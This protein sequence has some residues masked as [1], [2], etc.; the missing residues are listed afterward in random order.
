MRAAVIVDGR[1][2]IQERPDPVPGDGE[3]LIRV[4]AAGINGADLMQRAGNYPPPPGAPPDIPGLECAGETE[5]GE[6]VMALLAGGGQ[7][8]LAVVHESH[9]LPVP[10]VVGWPEAGG[11]VEAF[12][13][14]HDALFS[15]AELSA[16]ERLLVNGAAGGVGVAAVQLGLAAGAHVT[17]SARHH[18]DELR[19]LGADTDV[20]SEY[21]VI[22]ELVG[23]ENLASNLTRLASKGRVAVIGTGAGARIELDF[24]LLMR[25]RGRIHGSMLRAR[26]IAEKAQVMTALAAFT[27]E[28]TFRVPV[29]ETFP[30][31]RTQDAY[32]RF[33][34]GNKFGK[35]IVCP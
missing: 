18:H 16:G 20:D 22:L 26:S 1:I 2:E 17:A 15:Q 23:G 31:E 28:R 11:F 29:E 8:E 6:H 30:L 3:I 14:A 25:K 24:G 32:E 12:A 10:E 34:A 33:K 35:I 27:E 21:D 7:A 13:T 9:V 5:S 4:R 19:A